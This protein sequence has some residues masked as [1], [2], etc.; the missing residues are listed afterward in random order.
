[1]GRGEKEREGKPPA[2]SIKFKNIKLRPNKR[3]STK[4]N[5]NLE[6][7][8]FLT[9]LPSNFYFLKGVFPCR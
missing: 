2:L 5:I 9:R 7:L 4:I 1:M 8:N 6:Y 3:K